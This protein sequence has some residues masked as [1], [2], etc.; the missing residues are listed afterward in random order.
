MRLHTRLLLTVGTVLVCGFGVI[1]YLFYWN[2]KT[3]TENLFKREAEMIRAMTMATHHVFHKQ[4]AES[5]LELN[6]KTLGFLPEHATNKISEDLPNWTD[7]GF[8][9]KNVSDRPRNPYLKADAHELK[10]IEYFNRNPDDKTYF[11]PFKDQTGASFF[12]FASPIWIEESCISC[13]GEKENAPPSSLEYKDAAYGYSLGDLRGLLVITLP[14]SKVENLVW[15]NF[16]A[17]FLV[18]LA[19]FLVLFALLSSLLKRY[20]TVPLSSL[21]IGIKRISENKYEERLDPLEGEFGD[22]GQEFNSMAEKLMVRFDQISKASV[23]MK[24]LS[25]VLQQSP[26]SIVIT[27]LEGNIEYVNPAFSQITGYS[28]EE[29][30]SQNPRLLNSGYHE[31]AFFEDMWNTILS[32]RV[33]QAEILNRKKNGELFWEKISTSPVK[34]E[35]D[36][37]THFVSVK[38]DITSHKQAES[39]LKWELALNSSL[40]EV[41]AGLLS[42]KQ[43]IGKIGSLIMSCAVKLTGCATGCVGLIDRS[44]GDFACSTKP[45]FEPGCII[46]EGR[47]QKLPKNKDGTFQGLWG[48][49]LNSQDCLLTNQPGMHPDSL[50]QDHDPAPLNQFLCVPVILN[51]AIAGQ[52]AI[53]N[54]GREFTEQDLSAVKRLAELY[55]LALQQYWAG[56]DN[57]ELQKRLQ[58][59]QK[60]EAIGTLAGGIAHDFNNILTTIL[61]YSEMLMNDPPNEQELKEDLKVILDSAFRA[62]HLVAQILTF[63]RQ[64]EENPVAIKVQ[65]IL[66][67]TLKFTRATF[68]TTID[69]QHRIDPDCRPVLATPTEIHQVIMN[70]LTNARQAMGEE[71]GVLHIS[72]KEVVLDQ[73]QIAKSRM[74]RGNYIC[75]T[76]SDTGTGMSPA[77][78][79]RIFE[80]YF[81]TKDVDKG[82]GLGLAVCHGIVMKYGGTITVK[83]VPGSGSV[84]E[85]F[86]PVAESTLPEGPEV[87]LELFAQGSKS[88]LLVDDEPGILHMLNKMLAGM[89]Y[90]V[91]TR[92][93]GLEA[94]DLFRLNPEEF[95]LL[96]TDATMPEMTGEQLSTKV[97]E[98]KPGFPIIMC[99]GYSER[100]SAERAE[101]LGVRALLMKPV[102]RQDIA[103][104]IRT[105]LSKQD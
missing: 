90:K 61:G 54:P 31:K 6:E 81:T 41:S 53:A 22:L 84:F 71:K 20:V 1:E 51:N 36:E 92:A 69:I 97:L 11:S 12:L 7:S 94:W 16:R 101:T 42:E 9:V 45:G 39:Q 105:A 75:L 63:A 62:K 8:Q 33:F 27:D 49:A 19:I 59:T 88:I 83:S 32:G 28:F 73:D 10:A 35:Q 89:G 64:K 47:E 37:I 67:E 14:V 70:L 26:T 86:L 25:M 98:V 104:S 13:H 93:N 103:L 91:T 74:S 44:S 79:D 23:E 80:P 40:A 87:P 68:P 65:S 76:I 46:S 96:I 38:M 18:H 56:F 3:A 60:M 85:V 66:N 5:G 78:L 24:K 99:S 48:H 58:Q 57:L 34:N 50:P 29:A 102:S 55:T 2:T 100:M 77:V 52:I 4:L 95:D 82:T 17:T 43:N 21:T 72:L 30:L 15:V